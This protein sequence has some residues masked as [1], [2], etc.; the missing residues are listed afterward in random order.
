LLA[1]GAHH[2][3]GPTQYTDRSF[4]HLKLSSGPR[5]RRN[6]NRLIRVRMVANK[7]RVIANS[8]VWDMTYRAWRTTFAPMLISFFRS[9]VI[10]QCFT[11]LSSASRR[12]E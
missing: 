2:N 6:R 8:A 3:D 11:G 4:E 1:A 9:V 7:S 12:G 10:D 5:Q